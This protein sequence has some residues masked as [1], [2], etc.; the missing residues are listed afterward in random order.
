MFI[1]LWVSS[2]TLNRRGNTLNPRDKASVG[3]GTCCSWILICLP[4]L[5]V[6]GLP[7]VVGAA[8]AGSTWFTRCGGCRL[9][10]MPPAMHSDDR[11]HPKD[12]GSI[13]WVLA[14]SPARLCKLGGFTAWRPGGGFVEGIAIQEHYHEVYTFVTPKILPTACSWVNPQK[15]AVPTNEALNP[16]P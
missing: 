10:G 12:G 4:W 7:G 8:M 6:L 13:G 16:K 11:S 9:G 2:N 14:R 3:L 15:R 1:I 5:A